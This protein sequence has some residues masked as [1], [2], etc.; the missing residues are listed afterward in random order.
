MTQENFARN[1]SLSAAMAAREGV[2]LDIETMETEF[3]DT[4]EKAAAWVKI[5]NSPYLQIYPD[6]GNITNASAKY[7]TDVLSDLA[8]GRGHL[9]AMHLKE[10]VPGIFQ[11]KSF[12]TTQLTAF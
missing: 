10:T 6:I 12:G 11:Y 2:V 7:G 8:A 5:I 3:I 1:L 4:V 9:A